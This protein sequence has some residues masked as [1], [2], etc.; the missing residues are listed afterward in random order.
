MPGDVD[1]LGRRHYIRVD[2][3]NYDNEAPWPLAADGGGASP[4]RVSMQLYGND[5]NNWAA[6]SPPTPGRCR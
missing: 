2:M 4:G 1:E 5:P 3:V 6:V